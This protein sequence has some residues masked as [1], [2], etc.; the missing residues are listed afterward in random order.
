MSIGGGFIVPG[1]QLLE[2]FGCQFVDAERGV[3]A[4]ARVAGYAVEIAV[5]KQSLLQGRERDEADAVCAAVFESAVV[6]GFLA[7]HVEFVLEDEQGHVAFAQVSV[8]E[9]Q[10]LEG[11]ARDTD[12]ERLPRLHRSEKFRHSRLCDKNRME[13][14]L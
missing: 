7:Q 1:A 12:V 5:G 4:H 10:R 13:C 6:D 3:A 11:P 9:F 14:F 8:S 2:Q